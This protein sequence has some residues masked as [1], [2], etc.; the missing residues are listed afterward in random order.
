MR[1]KTDTTMRMI[2]FNRISTIL[3]WLFIFAAATL[4]ADVTV[5]TFHDKNND[6]LRDADENPISGLIVTATDVFG[7]EL[8]LLDDGA[9]T[10]FLP[11]A[12]IRSRL[13]IQ[14]KGYDATDNL[15]HGVAGPSSVFFV[16]DGAQVEVP[17]S[18]GPNFN[19]LES[20]ILIPCYGGG[21][22]E[23]NKG[24]AFV[25]FPYSVDGISAQYGGSAPAPSVDA[26]IEQIGSSWG[27]AYQVERQRAFVSTVLKRHVG[28]GPEG[29]GGLYTVDYS[30]GQPVVSGIDLNN[31]VPSVGPAIDLGNI[32]R[33]NVTG[34]VNGDMPYAL[35]FTPET[36]TYDMDAF[37]KVGKAAF[38]DIDVFEDEIW[39]VNLKQRSLI[40]LDASQDQVSGSSAG[41][42]HYPISEM[43]GLPNLNYAYSMCINA[44]GNLNGT[45]SEPFTDKNR[46]SWDKNKYSA[47]GRSSYRAFT[48]GN[49][50]NPDLKTSEKQL[51]QTYRRGNFEYN[52]P[53]PTKAT[54]TVIL[55]FAD[56]TSSGDGDRLFD[57]IVEGQTMYQ[58]FD[59]V[60]NAEG[61]SRATTLKFEI[62]S[63]DNNELN[64]S[65]QGKKGE[66]LVSGIEITGG[67]IMES[68]VL[69]PWGLTFE[70]GKGYLGVVADA[71]MSQ[72]RDHLFGFVLSFDPKNM[73]QGFFEELAFPLAY[74]RER[75]SNAHLPS[76]QP[77]RAA[78]WQPWISN[79]DQTAIL[80]T[81]E[82]LSTTQ[83][84][85]CAYPQPVISDIDFTDDGGLVLGIMDRF[86]HQTGFRNYPPKLDDSTLLVTYGAGDLIRVFDDNN[87]FRIESANDVNDQGVFFRKDDGPSFAGEFFYD[88]HFV[89]AA[90]HHGEIFTG[91]LGI[92]PSSGEVVNT[93]FNPI[94]TSANSN[95]DNSGVYTQG[96]HFYDTEDGAKER[97]YLF[98]GQRQP[99]GK[100]N[101]LG[102]M[103]FASAL[104]GGEIGNYVWCDGNG[105]GIQD[106][107][108][109][110]IDGIEVTLHD[111]E[112][113]D[114]LVEMTTTANGGEFIFT[115]LLPNHCYSMRI[116]LSQPALADFSGLVPDPEQGMDTLLDSNG[117]PDMIPGFTVAMVC[118]G[119]V[120]TNDHSIDFAF[121]GPIANE[122]TL[123]ACDDGA[124]GMVA[125]ADFLLD[126]IRACVREAGTMNVVGIYEDLVNDSLVNE[127]TTGPIRVCG[128]DSCVYAR[129]SLPGDTMCFA[130]SKVTLSVIDPANMGM[131]EFGRLVCASDVLDLNLEL[132]NFALSYSTATFYTDEMKTMQIL[133][134][135]MY[136]PASLPDTTYFMATLAGGG[137]DVMGSMIFTEI[138]ISS[139]LPGPDD[140]ICGLQCVDLTAL[141]FVFDANGSGATEAE[142][143]SSGS[144]SFIDDNTFAGARF[145]CPD[146]MDLMNGSVT[147]TLTVLNDPCA[148]APP[149]GS[150]LITVVPPVPVTIPGT[151]DTIDCTHPFATEQTPANDTFP[152]CRMVFT[153]EDTIQ[154]EVIDYQLIPGD[155]E[156]IIKMIKRT[157]RIVYNKEEFFCMD[158]ISI[159]AL[160]DTIIC[161]PERDSVYC[162]TGYLKDENGNPSPL[163]TGFP[164]AD[165]IPLWPEVPGI[166]DILVVY[167]D[168]K[169]DDNCPMTIRREWFIKNSC[170]GAS[171]SC[172]QWLMVFDTIGPYI[173]KDTT[174]AVFDESGN[175]LVPTGT[176]DCE[177]HTYIPS[178][179][180]SDTCSDVKMVKAVIP[181]L[182]TVVLEYNATDGIWESH[183]QVK[184]PK[185]EDPTPVYYEAYDHC[186][187]VTYDTCYLRVKDFVKPV[188][189]CDKGVNVTVTDTTVWVPATTFDEGS[190]DN[191][192]INLLL[193]RRVD[194]A[195]ACGVDLC[196][197]L[198][199]V[200]ATEH[201]DS[202]W[203]A[204]LE[205]DKHV[206]PVE[207]HYAKT[208]EWLCED[209]QE[210]SSIMLAGWAY[211]LMKY[212]TIEC[213]DHPYDFTEAFFRQLLK[214]DSCYLDIDGTG[215]YGFN[216]PLEVGLGFLS[217]YKNDTLVDLDQAASDAHKVT[218]FLPVE[219]TYA[220]FGAQIGGGW[221]EEVP[222]CCEDA[223]Q[224]V[225]VELLAM[226]Y[227]CNWSKCWTIVKVEDKTPPEVVCE[228][229]D[230]TLSCASY[231]TY[232][233]DAVNMA[234]AGDYDSLQSVL[235][236]YDKVAYD[237]YG[238]V[239]EKT[240]F[241]IYE[242]DCDSN[243]VE[244]DSLV[245]DEHLGYVWKTF[246]YYRAEY[247]T[248]SRTQ[249]NGQVADNCGLQCIELKPW[250]SIDHCGYG[251]V[252]RVFKFVGQCFDDGTG[253]KTD[254]LTRTQTIY[255]QPDCHISKAMFEVPKDTIVYD[256]GITYA[257]DGSGNAAG[258]AAPENTG[259]AEY[260]F[261]N[262]CRLV[263]I[264]YYDKVFKVVGGDLGCYKIIRTWCFADWCAID[265]EVPTSK[266][267]WWDPYYDGKYLTCTQKIILLDSTPPI[268]TIDSIGAQVETAGCYYTLDTDVTIEDECGV[269]KYSWKVTDAKS[270]NLF[271]SGSGELN[272]ETID[273]FNIH[274][275]DI[276]AGSYSLK[277]VV[278]DECQNESICDHPFDVIANKRPSPV[279]L[280]SL[281]VELTP[282]D[283]D[284]DGQAD[285]AMAV[286]WAEEFDQ[287][288]SAACGS[289]D[290]ELIFL[291]DDGEGDPV[292]PETTATSLEVGCN[293]VGPNVVR[294]Y[295]LDESGSWDYCS[296]ILEVQNN[297]G[298]CGDISANNGLVMGSILTEA[299][300]LIELV[301]VSI[302]H[303]N[304]GL[305]LHEQDVSGSYE[306]VIPK[307]L[308]VVV[309]PEK[310]TDYDNGVSTRDLVKI[311]KHILGKGSLESF[312][313]EEAADANGDGNIGALDLI[314][315]R[316]LILGK[317][318]V[319]PGSP[320]WRFYERETKKQAYPISETIDLMEIDFVGV[321]IGDVNGDNRPDR[322]APRSLEQRTLVVNDA[323]LTPGQSFRIPIRASDFEQIE[324]FQFTLEVDPAV[325]KLDGVTAG[326]IPVS[327]QYFHVSKVGDWLTMAWH[328][329]TG[330][331]VNAAE[332]E[333]LFY[334]DLTALAT[335]QLSDAMTLN[336]KQIDSEIY[337]FGE[338]TRGLGLTFKS[339]SRANFEL[340]QN[341]PNPFGLETRIGF[342]L[343]EAS[344][345]VISI[346]DVTGKMIKELR[347]D[348]LKGYNEWKVEGLDAELPGGVLYYKLQ[349]QEFT[350]VKKMILMR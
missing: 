303:S 208:I 119:P 334:I 103:E 150:V 319:L 107:Q 227:W 325:V 318:D 226:D 335:A 280:T 350:D 328:D 237:S 235:G 88:D 331:A 234:L 289:A 56:P 184:I 273:F 126:D 112:N 298:G 138:P 297:M 100:A 29:E 204:V 170:T 302:E 249:Y 243:L 147:L 47:G 256:C 177:A 296:V 255:I 185:S 115:E 149:S 316:K 31:V 118:T 224:E 154:G 232:Y 229:Y 86:A 211:D 42:R 36:A 127:I 38:G 250:V 265:G 171:D 207:A 148:A 49:L 19:A 75:A 320:S 172:V 233:E 145:Y 311:Q 153:C 113:S 271:D 95:F 133:T 152:T 63:D 270:G 312:Y 40:A 155:C 1:T 166:C 117:D 187:N 74:P 48:P 105:N 198:Q 329:E 321:K 137:C 15:Q 6:G 62:E 252:K 201:H 159:R 44:G 132:T 12:L 21:P 180:A 10:F 277:V 104:I 349:S 129:V 143:S 101:G 50:L 111:K 169:F 28:L 3:C 257:G 168:F 77:L 99:N 295:V 344:A 81:E 64:F 343:P 54:Y 53:V 248:S 313:Q 279:C 32:M 7:D 162:H 65:F 25:S 92:L 291:I 158:T 94:V 114:E 285:T 23:E 167:K 268:C 71:S 186:H 67:P 55:H 258:A 199:L 348:G 188:T 337:P 37:D 346:Y 305:M 178:V 181:N 230:V 326:L 236:F 106:P 93:V 160:P 245:Y 260:V 14:V 84:L 286:V 72:A 9:G 30:S 309:R 151:T 128:P 41:I 69:R 202:I 161:P 339:E 13:R 51:Y 90:A 192:G 87:T 288:S 142:W 27:V 261:D 110:G 26:T 287:S 301:D 20:D 254:T 33:E 121:L 60:K 131:P 221:S 299:E 247:D 281:T 97:A 330:S 76:P 165:S 272:S 244:K 228:L 79:W 195:T 116:D 5:V 205:K 89:A 263:G 336:D 45:G 66:A 189:I 2:P 203:C 239:G 52:I 216:G 130:I 251:F 314:Q 219:N 215:F 58:D 213:V 24:P 134:P 11:G 176:H 174:K 156:D 240:S 175:V 218:E 39:L 217:C 61:T 135:A 278:T 68:G 18:T 197:S 182:A 43:S 304:G 96:I 191:C 57:I 78:A 91:G 300:D 140:T 136:M 144:G 253:H 282:M 333:V 238:N 83:A 267:W 183:Q 214:D 284:D 125:C 73:G 141:G 315:L 327:S 109:F 46:V 35:T 274:V 242:L 293:H 266:D 17:V 220:D 82:Q 200:C 317:S 283:L 264:G 163:E 338:D 308:N 157:S 34:D 225:M 231:K 196:D 345:A 209:G 259:Q 8:P 194:W 108:E 206:N 98:E 246:S 241:T 310:N 341:Q 173:E 124:G 340:F 85:L 123:V 102:D 290:S 322:R 306:F 292:L 276:P 323:K 332:S 222:F 59:I 22:A 275:E 347:G 269:L 139:I 307:G 210:C 16:E 120:G 342:N 164:M 4:Y 122:C 179:Y 223:C 212:G 193:A 146:S 294:M 262:D 324:G 190:W 80:T 70:N